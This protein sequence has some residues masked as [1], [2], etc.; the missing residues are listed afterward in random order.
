V[1]NSFGLYLKS[2]CEGNKDVRLFLDSS[3]GVYAYDDDIV[4]RD[5]VWD[6]NDLSFPKSK[7]GYSELIIKV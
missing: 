6:G 7:S 3:D 2:K 5:V 1:V 4:D